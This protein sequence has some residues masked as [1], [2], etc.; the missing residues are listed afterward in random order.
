MKSFKEFINEDE[1]CG[2]GAIIN[3]LPSPTRKTL[4]KPKKSIK[5][6]KETEWTKQLSDKEIKDHLEKSGAKSIFPAIIKHPYYTDYMVKSKI[7]PTNPLAIGERRWVHKVGEFGTH[8]IK[9]GHTFNPSEHLNF[10]VSKR[11]KIYTVKHVKVDTNSD[12]TKTYKDLK[13]MV[14]GKEE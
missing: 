6:S 11:G 1:P 3:S 5:E 2:G 10:H 7:H 13:R 14:D 4:I 12:G 8:E 9:V